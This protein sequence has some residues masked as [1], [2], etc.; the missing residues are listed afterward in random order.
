MTIWI[1]NAASFDGLSDEPDDVDS[2]DV[3]T[4]SGMEHE[5]SD[6]AVHLLSHSSDARDSARHRFIEFLQHNLGDL[7][8]LFCGLSQL[9]CHP[10]NELFVPS[11]GSNRRDLLGLALHFLLELGEKCQPFERNTRKGADG[12][13]LRSNLGDLLCRQTVGYQVTVRR[14]E[15]FQLGHQAVGLLSWSFRE[16]TS[17]A[18]HRFEQIGHAPAHH[19]LLLRCVNSPRRFE[20]A[21]SVLQRT[22]KGT[23]P[24]RD[25]VLQVGRCGRVTHRHRGYLGE[26][27]EGSNLIRRI[28]ESI[29]T[30][31]CDQQ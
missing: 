10:A 9:V 5:Q 21:C 31:R 23:G 25:A 11:A 6:P 19:L 28:R 16:P 17:I 4:D 27:L 7:V 13:E 18:R 26:A 8:D 29:H 20:D 24:F 1:G 14:G 3:D 12:L 30:S 2:S 15:F 22:K